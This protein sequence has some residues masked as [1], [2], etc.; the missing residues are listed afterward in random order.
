RDVV[1]SEYDSLCGRQV[2]SAHARE[3]VDRR[4][5]DHER[6][7]GPHHRQRRARRSARASPSPD[8]RPR[9]EEGTA[10]V[11]D[12]LLLEEGPGGGGLASARPLAVGCE[13]PGDPQ[14]GAKPL[15]RGLP[16][17]LEGG[18]LEP[19]EE[20]QRTAVVHRVAT[21]DEVAKT[22]LLDTPAQRGR[23]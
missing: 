3:P 15:L 5:L 22:Q 12:R 19:V 4:L 1:A 9:S 16:T 23:G 10:V 20:P 8:E 11:S 6:A 2:D 17:L 13:R 21:Y 7:K 14:N 18:R